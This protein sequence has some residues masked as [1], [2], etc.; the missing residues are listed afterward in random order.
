LRAR[1]IRSITCYFP[2]LCPQLIAV[3]IGGWCPHRHRLHRRLKFAPR[4]STSR[5]AAAGEPRLRTRCARPLRDCGCGARSQ[6]EPTSPADLQ[7]LGDSDGPSTGLGRRRR[8]CAPSRRL[9]PPPPPTPPPPMAA[10]R[11]DR[12]HSIACPVC[13]GCA[14]ARVGAA[15]EETCGRQQAEVPPAIQFA[16]VITADARWWLF[17]SPPI[18]RAVSSLAVSLLLPTT[19]PYSSTLTP[20]YSSTL[21][22]L[23]YCCLALPTCLVGTT[24]RGT[25]LSSPP[26]SSSSLLL[27]STSLL[28]SPLSPRPSSI[29][30]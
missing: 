20:P 7:P 3:R 16:V 27:P 18:T 9:E 15:C 22:P 14:R 26:S 1:N 12:H 21:T 19:P 30:G 2:H 24:P 10:R 23:G 8:P 17:V 28:V 6:R 5:L 29:P 4:L 13:V 25:P 11:P